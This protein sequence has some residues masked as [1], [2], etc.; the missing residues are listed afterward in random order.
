M[1]RYIEIWFCKKRK[2]FDVNIRWTDDSEQ[3][4]VYVVDTIEEVNEI[5]NNFY[6][7]L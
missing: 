3:H 2:E 6:K 5:V 7:D 1:D 4:E